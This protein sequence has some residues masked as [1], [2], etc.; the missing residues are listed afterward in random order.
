MGSWKLASLLSVAILLSGC[1][2]NVFLL[3]AEKM[4][5]ANVAMIQKSKND[6]VA[7]YYHLATVLS[8]D[9]Q[10]T[11]Y[12]LRDTGIYIPAGR[13]SLAVKYSAKDKPFSFRRAR[14]TLLFEA[15][16]GMT[17]RLAY[18]EDLTSV[19]FWIEDVATG[20]RVSNI[21]E[22]SVETFSDAG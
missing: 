11:G 19:S 9:G 8:V 7:F 6:T 16:G 21:V 4:D 3:G 17:F 22:A 14:A 20:G 12:N 15:I 5:S 10:S 18:K 2:G 13:R 1:A